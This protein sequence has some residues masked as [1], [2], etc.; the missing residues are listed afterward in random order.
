MH[1]IQWYLFSNTSVTWNGIHS[2]SCTNVFP[3]KYLPVVRLFGFLLVFPIF[4][5]TLRDMSSS[6]YAILQLNVTAAKMTVTF[7]VYLS[8]YGVS[9]SKITIQKQIIPFTRGR[10]AKQMQLPP[11]GLMLHTNSHWVLI[12]QICSLNVLHSDCAST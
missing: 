1:S 7:A 12:L 10:C 3:S 2:I 6:A 11:F 9:K 5:D 4:V 8:Y